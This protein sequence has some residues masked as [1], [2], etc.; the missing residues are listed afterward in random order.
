MTSSTLAASQPSWAAH[1][2][3]TYAAQAPGD[4]GT[5]MR[6]G[7]IYPTLALIPPLLI[8][9]GFAVLILRTYT[10]WRG[11]KLEKLAGQI[12]M[13]PAFLV[14]IWQSHT[15]LVV[16]P[17]FWDLDQYA[18]RQ[19]GTVA[20]CDFFATLYIACNFVQ[21]VGQIKT[22]KSPLREQLMIHHAL[23]IACYASSF[24][25]DQFRWWT[26]LAGICELTN[27]F[28][29]P[30]FACKEFFPEWKTHVSYRRLLLG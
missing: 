25:F 28:L 1:W 24:Y 4:V 15:T 29:I 7:C 10:T 21:A 12:S 26:A 17:R 9:Y 19:Q 13:Y 8:S 2:F 14:L 27:L 16:Y 30:V 18:W 6:E 22:E 23:S 20:E 3:G 11:L 5:R